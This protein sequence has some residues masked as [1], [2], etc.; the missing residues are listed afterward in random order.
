MLSN[1]EELKSKHEI[2]SLTTFGKDGVDIADDD[3]WFVRDLYIKDRHGIIKQTKSNIILYPTKITEG[4]RYDTVNRDFHFTKGT[5]LIILHGD[6]WTAIRE[7]QPESY[8]FVEKST[9]HQ[10]VNTSKN[11]DMSIE[12][13]HPGK[14]ERPY[15]TYIKGE[16]IPAATAAQQQQK[17]TKK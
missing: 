6:N 7:I 5:G 3:N 10:I 13:T 8:C 9:W 15:S 4:E 2:D 16:E 12:L 17:K 1:Q 11:E 14:L